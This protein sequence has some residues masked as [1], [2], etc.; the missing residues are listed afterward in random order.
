MGKKDN[1]CRSCWNR[2]FVRRNE[3]I[4][5]SIHLTICGLCS[6][7][8]I[9]FEA[10]YSNVFPKLS[11]PPFLSVYLVL[12][13]KKCW[14]W[15]YL[16]ELF[17]PLKFLACGLWISMMFL[18]FFGFLCLICFA[19]VFDCAYARKIVLWKKCWWLFF[20]TNRIFFIKWL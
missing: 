5:E 3:T 19:Y 12:G 8:V 9:S 4:N 15:R 1:V 10:T 11:S 6:G 13:E 18:S 17:I 2:C 7:G 20:S 14:L 16:V